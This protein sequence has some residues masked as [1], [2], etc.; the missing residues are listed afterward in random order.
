MIDQISFMLSK[1]KISQN[2]FFTFFFI[3]MTNINNGL[4]AQFIEEKILITMEDLLSNFWQVLFFILVYKY[5]YEKFAKSQ[6]FL[7]KKIR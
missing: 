5:I 4:I 6:F 2:R 3:A 7:K 1:E